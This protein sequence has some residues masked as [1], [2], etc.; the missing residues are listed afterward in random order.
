MSDIRRRAFITLL[1]AAVWPLAA[2]AQQDRRVRLIGVLMGTAEDDLHGQRYVAAFK[3]ALQELGW[4]EGS[5][6]QVDYRFGAADVERFQKVAK[7]L[8][9]SQPELLV[10]HTTPA[11]TALARETKTIPIV[12]VVVSDPVGS[13]LVASLA[14]P[15][16]NITG[17]VNIEAS[18]GGK[19]VEFLKEVSPRLARVALIYNP[20]TAPYSRYYLAS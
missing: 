4:I 11:T 5:N 8:V 16:G 1:G 18:V 17:F 14:R 12:F 9:N 3:Q 13:G 15:G 6:I 7:E 20:Q 19:W 10:G 2:R